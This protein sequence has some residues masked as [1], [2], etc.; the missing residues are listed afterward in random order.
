MFLYETPVF[1]E[2]A[3]RPVKVFSSNEL[4]VELACKT[5]QN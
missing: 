5:K 2:Q 4:V 3:D 1:M